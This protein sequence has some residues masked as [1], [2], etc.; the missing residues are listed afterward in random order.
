MQD[1]FTVGRFSVR[2]EQDTDPSNPREDDNFGHMVCFHSRYSL[3]DDGVGTNGKRTS[4]Q[5]SDPEAF[6]EFV[7]DKANGVAVCLALYL[8]DHS[9]ITMRVSDG[10]NPFRAFDSDEWDSGQVGWI[11]ATRED[12][13][14]NW[15]Y[16]R[17][18]KKRL[19]QARKL[20]IAEVET[21]D[22]YLTGDIWGYII[23]DEDGEHVDSCWGFY[24]SK[25]AESEARDAAEWHVKDD[26]RKMAADLLREFEMGAFINRSFAL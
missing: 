4:R 15:G 16:T 10:G 21:Y 23:E 18:T 3:G 7:E 6:R 17:L 12:I 9:G 19:E 25:D 26:E 8:Y 24:G 1:K 5:F 2:L 13:K 22:Q 14:A 11:Y 20:L